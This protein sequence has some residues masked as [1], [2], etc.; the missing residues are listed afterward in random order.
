[1]SVAYLFPGQGTPCENILHLLPDHPVVIGTI[2]EANTVLGTDS[3][4]LDGKAAVTSAV[5]AQLSIFIAGVASVRV[6]EAAGALPDAVAGLSIGAFAAAVTAG[7]VDF[8]ALLP[9]VRLRGEL[10]E[11]SFPAGY[12]LSVII[13]LDVRQVSELVAECHTAN[14]PVYLANL[15][16]PRQFVI[17]G[18]LRGLDEVLE[19][20]KILGARKAEHLPV[21]VPSHC[22]LLQEASAKL[23][24][25]I[26]G[27][28]LS[29]PRIPYVSNRH[30]RMLR[31]P[32][33]ILEDVVT[34]IGYP[35][36]WHDTT[37]LLYE[38]G[39]RLFIEAL[40]GHSL[41][42]LVL[43]AFPDCKGVP[44]E[45]T[46]LD[47]LLHYMARENRLSAFR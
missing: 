42:N 8:A 29:Q 17:A 43:E 33:A 13:G 23:L 31:D 36:Y 21:N 37:T 7:V 41:S 25:S 24:S 28:R 38:H 26:A 3:Y 34:N 11:D 1:M 27:V 16:A 47:S 22:P 10:M 2:E 32:K 15:N 18:C 4:L 6:L 44:F 14:S 5:N 9:V 12:G 35:V 30:A 40:P 19:N 46:P 39:V 20:A 45:S